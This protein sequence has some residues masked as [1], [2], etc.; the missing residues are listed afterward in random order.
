MAWAG[1]FFG[2]G[3]IKPNDGVDEAVHE[4]KD[5]VVVLESGKYAFIVDDE[6]FI[7]DGNIEVLIP[8]GA[9]HSIKN[10]GEKGSKIYLGYREINV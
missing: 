9:K 3:T 2:V 1:V 5:E 8:A 7:Q 6:S 4:D 10:I